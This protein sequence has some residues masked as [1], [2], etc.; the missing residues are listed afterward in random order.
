MKQKD[1]NG[2]YV[3]GGCAD[4]RA[5]GDEEK[6][7]GWD[8][9]IGTHDHALI[10]AQLVVTVNMQNAP[11]QRNVARER[12]EGGCRRAHARE[13][14]CVCAYIRMYIYIYISLC[15]CVCVSFLSFARPLSLSLSLTPSL[16]LSP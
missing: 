4:G 12:R 8:A 10:M 7:G 15:V 5:D 9:G 2:N 3:A 11:G 1:V 13:Y 16:P 14:V 6:G